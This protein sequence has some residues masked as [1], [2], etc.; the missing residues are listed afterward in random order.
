MKQIML[1]FWKENS[2]ILFFMIGSAIS[3]SIISFINADIVNALTSRNQSIFFTSALK[4]VICYTFF[5]LF[6][7]LKMRQVSATTQSMAT[8]LRVQTTKKLVYSGYQNFTKHSTGTYASWLTNDISQIEQLGFAPFYELVAGLI[9]SFIALGSLFFFHWSLVVLTLFEVVCLLQIPR[10]YKKAI[11]KKTHHVTKQ[12]EL[13]LEKATDFFNGF[14][15][16][17]SLNKQE[18]ILKKIM[19]YSTSLGQAKNNYVKTMA[20]VAITGGI[21][22]VLGQVSMFILTG[23][24][25]LIQKIALG[26]IAATGSLSAN[27]FNTVG[28]IS[29]FMSSINGT[30]PLFEKLAAIPE[31]DT[32]PYTTSTPMH[33]GIVLNNLRYQY[34][35]KVVLEDI[36]FSFELN[37]KYAIVGASGTGK[38]TLLNIITG[39]LLNYTGSV[40][41]NQHEIA[42]IQYEEITNQITYID[43]HTHL[44][45][46]S[47]RENLTLDD[48]FSDEQLWAVLELVDLKEFVAQLPEQLDTNVGE[49]AN[50]ISGGQAQRIGLARGLIREKHIL[51]IDEGTSSLD[52]KNL[53]MIEKYLVTK[54]E[55][56][57]I[58]VTHHLHPEIKEKLDGIL[59]L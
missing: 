58:M 24:L 19:S 30:K 51:I 28:N 32:H 6:T 16:L 38:S 55:L 50:L 18:F 7:Y 34:D 44:F 17:Y 13:F 10:L 5:L 35:S 11:A 47:V 29:Q 53:L 45:N 2:I 46:T 49:R 59:Q 12:N 48:S 54:K 52:Q 27:I 21:G 36:T 56:T 4:L 57:L 15:V 37:K 3:I 40:M 22:N 26:S 23:F 33:S 25:I 20:N 14:S 9:T 1:A 39:K 31:C 8:H 43:Q 41:L 42:A